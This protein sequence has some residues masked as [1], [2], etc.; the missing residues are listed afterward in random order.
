MAVNAALADAKQELVNAAGPEVQMLVQKKSR[1]TGPGRR[2]WYWKHYESDESSSKEFHRCRECIER[3]K[4][5]VAKAEASGR[6]P[7]TLKVIRKVR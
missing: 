3:N 5:A 6:D 7:Q 1:S 4:G 2:A